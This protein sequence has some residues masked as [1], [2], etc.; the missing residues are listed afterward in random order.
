MPFEAG[1]AGV[2][3]PFPDIGPA[4]ERL[5][6][7]HD[8]AAGLGAPPHVTVTFPFIPAAALTGCDFSA[9]AA[10]AAGQPA[11]EVTFAAI[12]RFPGVTHL[13][14]EPDGPFRKLT[15]ALLRRWPQ[16][17]PYGG[18]FGDAPEPHLTIAAETTD[19]VLT[20]IEEQLSDS[21][22]T[23]L[24]AAGLAVLIF[25]GSRWRQRDFLPFRAP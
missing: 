19:D 3:V 10:I 17:P 18:A 23:T 7:A 2:V 8:P 5:R 21:L 15:T 16:A 24:K 1:Q 13:R 4:I 14:P 22:P 12:G 11:F 6:Q 20:A 9:L 25:D